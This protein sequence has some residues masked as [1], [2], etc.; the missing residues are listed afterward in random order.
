VEVEREFAP[1]REGELERSVLDP[2][3]AE[4]ALGFR[5]RTALEDGLATTWEFVRRAEGKP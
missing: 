1:P 4:R 5:A 3:L 2:V